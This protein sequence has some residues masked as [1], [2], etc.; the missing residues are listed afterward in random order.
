M[1][2]SANA[3]LSPLGG[4][5]QGRMTGVAAFVSLGQRGVEVNAGA[6]GQNESQLRRVT[7]ESRRVDQAQPMRVMAIVPERCVAAPLQHEPQALEAAAINRGAPRAGRWG[8]P[9]G[10]ARR[11]GLGFAPSGRTVEE[12]HAPS[13]HPLD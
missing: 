5:L 11:H 10:P 7:P 13:H 3:Q 1:S 8:R 4:D 6:V 12:R 2:S 9:R